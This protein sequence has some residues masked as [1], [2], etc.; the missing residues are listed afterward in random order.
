LKQK[1]QQNNTNVRI[2]KAT[3]RIKAAKATMKKNLSENEELQAAIRA[4]QSLQHKNNELLR[5][6]GMLNKK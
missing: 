2:A 6:M 3:A 1:K 5:K 4:S